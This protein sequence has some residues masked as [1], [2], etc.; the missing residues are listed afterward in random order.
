MFQSCLIA[1]FAQSVANQNNQWLAR[2]LV[3]LVQFEYQM[4]LVEQKWK[5]LKTVEDAKINFLISKM[6]FNHVFN[7]SE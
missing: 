5:H 7:P 1:V 3:M 2:F 4:M 6:I